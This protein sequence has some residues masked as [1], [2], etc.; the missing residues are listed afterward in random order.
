[1]TTAR[2]LGVP[3]HHQ[4]PIARTLGVPVHH[5]VPI[6][7]TLGVP[8]QHQVPIARTLGVPVHHQ[9]P[10]ARTL[11]V[12][13]HHQVPIARTLGVPVHHQVPIARTLGVPVHHQVPIARTLGV[14]VHHQVLTAKTLSAS[15]HLRESA[16]IHNCHNSLSETAN[17]EIFNG[18]CLKYSRPLFRL[19]MSNECLA[20][21]TE[22]EST[23]VNCSWLYL[24]LQKIFTLAACFVPR[25]KPRSSAVCNIFQ[26]FF[27]R[28]YVFSEDKNKPY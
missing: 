24:L 25:N 2:T 16:V 28:Y 26:I 7:R 10:I 1:V 6:A 4:V 5:Q 22:S 11:C 20:K 13:V 19:M 17:F 15:E 23:A 14:P 12:P 9:V 18:D 21:D 27:T 3:V 8:V